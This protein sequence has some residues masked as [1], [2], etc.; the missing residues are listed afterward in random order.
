MMVADAF[1]PHPSPSTPRNLFSFS[2]EENL[3]YATLTPEANASLTPST[4]STYSKWSRPFLA[5]NR[6]LYGLTATT[7]RMHPEE[8]WR[9][10]ST[11][12]NSSLH[13]HASILPNA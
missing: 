9:I 8:K 2:F 12:D 6:I 1:Y 10:L 7:H 5:G 4:R 13:A 11:D 3:A